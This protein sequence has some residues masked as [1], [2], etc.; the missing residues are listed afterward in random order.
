MAI[1]KALYKSNLLR[2][3]YAIDQVMREANAE[4]SRENP[5][6]F[7]VTLLAGI[8]DLKSGVVEFSIAG[9][10]APILLRSGQSVRHLEGEGGPPL[11]VV[12][13]YPYP[14]ESFRLERGDTLVLV[15]DGVTEAH[16]GTERLYGMARTDALLGRQPPEAAPKAIVEALHADIVAFVGGTRQSD[17]IAILAIRYDGNPAG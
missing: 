17:D 7:F 13:D 1:T 2:G 8:L 9:H 11:C 14:V 4:I 5:A 12:D 16:D 15:T 3:R 6:H 10:D